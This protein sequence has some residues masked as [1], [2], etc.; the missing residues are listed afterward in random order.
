MKAWLIKVNDCLVTWF[1]CFSRNKV[2]ILNECF[3]LHNTINA[4]QLYI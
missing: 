1:N 3:I 2:Q 4:I